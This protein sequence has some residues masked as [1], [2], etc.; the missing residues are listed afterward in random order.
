MEHAMSENVLGATRPIHHLFLETLPTWRRDW[1]KGFASYCEHGKNH[2]QCEQCLV[3][4]SG[5]S[6]AAMGG[7]IHKHRLFEF[8]F[9][10]SIWNF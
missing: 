5:N 10:Q 7:K 6:Q 1:L 2:A 4:M 9:R 3:A 8:L